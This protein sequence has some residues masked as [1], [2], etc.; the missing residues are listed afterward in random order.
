MKRIALIAFIV[1]VLMASL[2][3]VAQ[4]CE[5]ND[6]PAFMTIGFA[7]YVLIISATAYYLTSILYEWSKETEAWQG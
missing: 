1:G 2:A 6:L 5:W 3:Y 4:L 7:G